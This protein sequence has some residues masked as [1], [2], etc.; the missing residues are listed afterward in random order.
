MKILETYS[1]HTSTT[2]PEHYEEMNTGFIQTPES[3]NERE[4]NTGFIQKPEHFD[5]VD[6]NTGFT[7]T[8]GPVDTDEN[9]LNEG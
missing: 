4:P 3:T 8:S 9:G 5:E 7:Q 6:L 2:N 1:S